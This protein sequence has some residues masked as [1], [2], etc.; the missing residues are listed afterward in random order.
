M[1]ECNFCGSSADK[2]T[3]FETRNDGIAYYCSLCRELVPR[4]QLDYPSREWENK[5][6]ALL[7]VNAV[8]FV[9]LRLAAVARE[10]HDLKIKINERY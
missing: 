1:D 4:S 7:I 9:S 2:V 3:E 5:D 10:L 6:L 8:R